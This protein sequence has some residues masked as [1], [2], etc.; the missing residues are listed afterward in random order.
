LLTYPSVALLALESLVAVVDPCLLLLG[1][2]RVVR[3]WPRP[4]SLAAAVPIVVHEEPAPRH[5]LRVIR[6]ELLVSPLRSSLFSSSLIAHRLRSVVSSAGAGAGGVSGRRS[7]LTRSLAVAAVR[8]GG[9]GGR[10]ASGLLPPAAS[11]SG[12]LLLLRPLRAGRLL[13]LLDAVLFA[14]RW[15]CGCSC[16]P[17]D[18]GVDVAISG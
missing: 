10:G 2:V 15:R 17:L 3:A 11:L 16:A 5:E 9:G 18:V 12:L 4:R 8:S 7:D 6:I 14:G 13:L 1:V